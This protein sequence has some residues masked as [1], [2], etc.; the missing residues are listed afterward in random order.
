M[1]F[2]TFQTSFHSKILPLQSPC[3]VYTSI[4]YSDQP[5]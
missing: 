3:T 4:M 2:F 1:I 5:F